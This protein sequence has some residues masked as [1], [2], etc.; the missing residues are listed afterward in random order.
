MKNNIQVQ[1]MFAQ[2][3]Q[4]TIKKLTGARRINV[5]NPT[6]LIS[7]H[8]PITWRINNNPIQKYTINQII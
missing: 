2:E 8:N 6:S 4:R 1:I 5:D 3:P 7:I